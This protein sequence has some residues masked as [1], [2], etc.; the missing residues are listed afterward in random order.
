MCSQS[1]GARRAYARRTCHSAKNERQDRTM[2]GCSAFISVSAFRIASRSPVEPLGSIVQLLWGWVERG[3]NVTPPIMRRQWPA[4]PPSRVVR[5][6]TSNSVIS[7]VVISAQPPTMR[8]FASDGS[9]SRPVLDHTVS[10]R[11]GQS[12]ECQPSNRLKD[13]AAT[14]CKVASLHWQRH[15]AGVSAQ[16]PLPARTFAAHRRLDRKRF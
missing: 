3:C 13:V 1:A 9:M 6:W 5:S 10:M 15:M 16:R 12:V 2:N 14:G 11:T 7:N 4:V 8:V